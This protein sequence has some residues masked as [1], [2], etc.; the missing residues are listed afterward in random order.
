[1]KHILLIGPLTNK[2]EPSKSGGTVVLFELLLEELRKKNIPFHV[3]D[4]LKENYFNALTAYIAIV[5]QLFRDIRKYEYI[6][7]HATANSFIWVGPIMIFLAKFFNKKTSIRKFAGNFDQ[8]YQ[9]SNG[10]KGFLIEYVLQNSDVNFFETKY[11]VD[12]FKRYYP[13]TYWFPNVRQAKHY[14][15]LPRSYHKRFVYIGTLNEEK[16][17]D[18]LIKVSKSL[19]NTYKLD[20]YGPIIDKKYSQDYFNKHQVRYK[21]ALKS[22]EVIDILNRYDV[23]ILPSYREGYP[24]IIIEAFSLGIPVIATKLDGIMEMIEEHKNGLLIDVKNSKQLLHTILHFDA[25]NYQKLSF[26]AFD[27]F[28]DFNSTKQT[29]LFLKRAGIHV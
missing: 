16:G 5:F 12:Y 28:K 13:H 2:K 3:I 29:E 1:L 20:L 14:P 27:A 4:T 26:G 11:L 9:E 10:L 17:I 23:L 21:G 7:L 22:D 6:S 24:G 19:D 8:I 15:T 18:E 25:I